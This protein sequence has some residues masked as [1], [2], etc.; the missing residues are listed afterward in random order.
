MLSTFH[1]FWHQ[2]GSRR[3]VLETLF[4]SCKLRYGG[5]VFAGM[6]NSQKCHQID[7]GEVYACTSQGLLHLPCPCPVLSLCYYCTNN[8]SLSSVSNMLSPTYVQNHQETYAHL[9]RH[10]YFSDHMAV[11]L[12]QLAPIQSEVHR[13]CI[14]IRLLAHIVCGIA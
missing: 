5:S 6:T 12:S 1:T 4:L 8:A 11:A 14:H 9:R 13:W 7:S 2:K 10:I 3:A